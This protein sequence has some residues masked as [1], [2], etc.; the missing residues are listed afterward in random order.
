MFKKDKTAR[1]YRVFHFNDDYNITCSLQ[2]SSSVEP[3]IWLGIDEPE[4]KIKYK[5]SEALGLGLQKL[6]PECNEDGW[7]N[8]PIPQEVLVSSR[9]HL[10]QKQAKKLG[11]ALLKFAE[12]GD[13]K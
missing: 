4:H 5:D 8:Y 11:E 6:Y 13:L 7:C 10:N 2:E 12:R 9:M 1:G 3:H